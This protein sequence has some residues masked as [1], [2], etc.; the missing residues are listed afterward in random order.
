MADRRQE[1]F[2]LFRNTAKVAPA[3]TVAFVADRLQ[4]ALT[5]P[6]SSVQVS[7]T[8]WPRETRYQLI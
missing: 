8:A 7:P 1:L 6:A 4:S 3:E 5:N 2:T